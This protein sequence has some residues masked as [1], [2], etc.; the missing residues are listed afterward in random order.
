MCTS[1]IIQ[2]PGDFLT[3][4]VTNDALMCY[5]VT[6]FKRRMAEKCAAVLF[7]IQDLSGVVWLSIFTFVMYLQELGERLMF[8]EGDNNIHRQ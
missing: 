1:G 3:P 2:D 7:I 5:L 6:V 8:L 4:S